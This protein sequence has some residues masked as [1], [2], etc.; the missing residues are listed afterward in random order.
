[1]IY[2]FILFT[3]LPVVVANLKEVTEKLAFQP[4]TPASTWSTPTTSVDSPVSGCVSTQAVSDDMVRT[5]SVVSSSV[6]PLRGTV[7]FCT[8]Y[9]FVVVLTTEEP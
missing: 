3:E 4:S 8:P 7:A 9:C 2:M 1:M 6:C 5:Q